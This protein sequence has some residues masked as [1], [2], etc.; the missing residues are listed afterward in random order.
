MT[1]VKLKGPATIQ[2]LM[3]LP[4]DGRIHELVDGE[5]VVSP[6]GMRHSEVGL[7]I[8]SLLANFLASNPVGRV[9]AAD[10]GIL[11]PNGNLRCPDVTFVSMGKLP[12]G[13]SPDSYGSFVPDLAVEVLSP[14]DSMKEVGEKIGEYFEN[15]VPLVWLV[16]P[17]RETVTVYRSLTDAQLLTS[18]DTITA[19]PILP[20][21]SS[22]VS[23]FF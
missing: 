10:V 7:K 13:K 23:H 22:P 2:D 16:D 11:F 6:A 21:F 9:Y 12:D 5:I 17:R 14:G 15:S 3:N 19:E 20:G 18:A 8:G 1:V 4:R